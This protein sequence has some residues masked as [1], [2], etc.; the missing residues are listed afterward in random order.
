MAIKCLNEVVGLGERCISENNFAQMNAMFL[1]KP[2]VQFDTYSDFADEDV[3]NTKIIAG[4]IIPIL[5][6]EEVENQNG[7]DFIYTTPSG[8]KIKNGDGVRGQGFKLILDLKSH[9]ILRSYS[10]KN[11]GCFTADM[12]KNIKGTSPDGTVVKPF[13]LQYFQVG[14]QLDP[15]AGGDPAFTPVEYQMKDVEEWETDGVYLNNPLFLPSQLQGVG[16]VVITQVG[17]LSTNDFVIDVLYTDTKALNGQS[18]G[19]AATAAIE[20]AVVANFLVLDPSGAA[21]T[22]TS[23]TPDTVEEGR[24]AFVNPSL[25]A[26]VKLVATATLKYTSNTLTLA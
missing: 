19:A 25:P 22:P 5:S 6:I 10:G 26:T 8:R 21:I 24:Y 7:E 9:Q 17:T 4:D 23:V 2:G 20:G 18:S 15:V 16:T 12:N 13:N 11:W 1:A 3:W 14:M